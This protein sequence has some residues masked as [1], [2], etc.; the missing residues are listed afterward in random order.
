MRWRIDGCPGQRR[1][2]YRVGLL[3]NVCHK[4]LPMRE[5]LSNFVRRRLRGGGGGAR[6]QRKALVLER[7]ERDFSVRG[8][9]SSLCAKTPRRWLG[10]PDS[11]RRRVPPT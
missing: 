2:A 6:R 11:E 10:A 8:A 3:E 1:G 4:R 5:C 9:S 7:R